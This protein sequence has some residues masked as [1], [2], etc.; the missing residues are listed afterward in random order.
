MQSQAIGGRILLGIFSA[1]IDL[2]LIA[3]LSFDAC[4]QGI[5]ASACISTLCASESCRYTG[6]MLLLGM[7]GQGALASV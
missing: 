3:V 7:L 5:F 2:G 1:L 6:A 4:L